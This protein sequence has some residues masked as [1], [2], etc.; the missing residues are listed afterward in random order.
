[1]EFEAISKA[2]NLLPLGNHFLAHFQNRAKFLG[3][4]SAPMLLSHNYSHHFIHWANKEEVSGAF[5]LIT[6][7]MTS[8]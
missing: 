3:L 5:L 6:E 1:L 2:W 4:S 8:D 7:P